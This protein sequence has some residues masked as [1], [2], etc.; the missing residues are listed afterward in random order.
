MTID[1]I[2]PPNPPPRG[3]SKRQRIIPHPPGFYAKPPRRWK[4]LL[5]KSSPLLAVVLFGIV[6]LTATPREPVKTVIRCNAS[7]VGDPGL[8]SDPG[9]WKR[10]DN[11]PMYVTN[12]ASQAVFHVADGYTCK[13][14]SP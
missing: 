14:E 11:T 5:L 12:D 9:V 1:Q 6:T 7:L 10:A 4:S 13:M 2:D 3:E 8:V